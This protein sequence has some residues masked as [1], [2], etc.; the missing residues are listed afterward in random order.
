V[1]SNT[2]VTYPEKHLELLQAA[3]QL[4]AERGYHN[5]SIRDLSEATGRSLSGLYYY[6]SGKDELLYQVQHHCYSTLRDTLPDALAAARTPRQKL[7]AFVGHHLSFFRDNMNEMK[8]LAHEDLT[9]AGEYGE[10]LR[11]L[12]RSY[13]QI[14]IDILAEFAQANPSPNR[15]APEVAAFLL[16]GSMNWLYTWP[17]RLRQLPPEELAQA[18]LQLFLCGYNTCPAADLG[19]IRESLSCPPRPIWRQEALEEP[20]GHLPSEGDA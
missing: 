2:A 13:S 7:I 6:F 12:K 19:G 15:P 4:F 3:S 18:V 20:D 17:R 11:V 1:S 10:R 8:V 5:T 9:L 14:L 16:F